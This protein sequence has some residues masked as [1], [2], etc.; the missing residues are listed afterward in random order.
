MAAVAMLPSAL[1]SADDSCWRTVPL[2]QTIEAEDGAAPFRL[3][4][5]TRICWSGEGGDMMRNASFLASYISGSTGFTLETE[6]IP[7]TEAIRE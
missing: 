3:T 7:D 4:P 1:A 2:P 5:S 6:E